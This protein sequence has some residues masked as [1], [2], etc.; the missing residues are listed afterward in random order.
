MY[1][2]TQI[3]RFA[4]QSALRRNK[5]VFALLRRDKFSILHYTLTRFPIEALARDFTRFWMLIVFHTKNGG[6]V[7]MLAGSADCVFQN[8]TVFFSEFF[9]VN[10]CRMNYDDVNDYKRPNLP[11]FV[12][13]KIE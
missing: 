9:V 4:N 5:S 7:E 2:Q 6:F 8:F 12:I 13:D 10:I 3:D 11:I 1:L